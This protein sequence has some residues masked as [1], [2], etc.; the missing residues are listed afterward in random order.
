MWDDHLYRLVGSF[1]D[2]IFL[3]LI[4][5]FGTLISLFKYQTKKNATFFFL[6]S[7]FLLT[8]T[9]TYSRASYLALI[10]GLIT[11]LFSKKNFLKFLRPVVL[12]LLIFALS[13]LF[14]PKHEGEGVRLERTS[15]IFARISS[16]QE[17]INIFSKYPLF[18]VGFNNIC[19]Y[20][21]NYS[22]K[23]NQLIF[24]NACYGADSSF[25]LILATSG[26][27]GFISFFST[28]LLIF[29]KSLFNKNKLLFFATTFALLIHTQLANSLFY[30]WVL[31][32]YI[33][34]FVTSLKE[35]K[36]HN[37]E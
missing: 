36:V 6:F 15:S 20:R 34:I 16:Y 29:R 26:V 24:S 9:F 35:L 14:L 19:K 12:S 30:S 25:L 1:L 17:V 11:F 23:S 10:T 13:F 27:V 21:L 4:L 22:D 7:Y 37:E 18:G 32:F 3:G 28:I 33:G 8:T 5:V 31:G 2:P